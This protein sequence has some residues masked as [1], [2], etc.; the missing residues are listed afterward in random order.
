MSKK[1]WVH[2]KLVAEV[3]AEDADEAWYKAVDMVRDGG[4]EIT[5]HTICD[6]TGP[7]EEVMT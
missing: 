3:E 7:I 6:E 1:L 2:F 4:G 5:G